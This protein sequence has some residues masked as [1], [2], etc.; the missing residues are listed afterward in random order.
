MPVQNS[1]LSNAVSKMGIYSKNDSKSS[2]NLKQRQ[3]LRQKNQSLMSEY[4]FGKKN[5]VLGES[6]K[7][8][9]VGGFGGHRF[10]SLEQNSPLNN[11]MPG[12]GTLQGERSPFIM[13]IFNTGN[14]IEGRGHLL[15]KS[16]D[17]F[18]RFGF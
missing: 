5:L 2:L 15:K 1:R 4:E 18:S 12:A 11:T 3:D 9:L 8:N 6:P 14:P 17:A 13:Q 7:S 16:K 10:G